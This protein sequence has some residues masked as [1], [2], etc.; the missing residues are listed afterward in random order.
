LGEI[1]TRATRMHPLESLDVVK[2]TLQFMMDRPDPL[3]RELPP[4]PGSR[5]ERYAQLLCP[6][7]HAL[8]APVGE[9]SGEVQSSPAA[10]GGS[11]LAARVEKLEQ[12]LAQL[13]QVVERLAK[14]LGETDIFP[15]PPAV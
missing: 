2:N 6:D 12:E 9:Q 4:S 7:L 14:S 5:A 13:H 3:V 1:R 10:S 8:N 11:T 15:P